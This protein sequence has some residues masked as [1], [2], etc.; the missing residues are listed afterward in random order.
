[1]K[2]DP[3]AKKLVTEI[4]TL[5]DIEIDGNRPWDIK[6]HDERFY[7]AVLQGGSLAFGETYMAKWWDSDDI[8][9]MVARIVHNQIAK[10]V[11]FTPGNILLFLRSFLRNQGAK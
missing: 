2:K 9:E 5:A 11:R 6:V 7:G 3:G 4:L 8:P 10:R 1:M